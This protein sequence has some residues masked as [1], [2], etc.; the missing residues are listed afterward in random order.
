M[1]RR[2]HLLSILRDRE[3][4]NSPKWI[5]F[6]NARSLVPSFSLCLYTHTH[7]RVTGGAENYSIAERAG[8]SRYT[9][10]GKFLV[11]SQII[12]CCFFPSFAWREILM[13]WEEEAETED[14]F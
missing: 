3:S 6:S 5:K 10:G 7:V 8:N 2:L 11:F 13:P 14:T 9:A 1:A 12:E 4:R